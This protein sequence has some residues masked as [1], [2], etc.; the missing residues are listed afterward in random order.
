[1]YA[2]DGSML[3]YACKLMLSFAHTRELSTYMTVR[4][5]CMARSTWLQGTLPPQ[6]RSS[7]VADN[8]RYAWHCYQEH[9][10]LSVFS[11]P[12]NVFHLPGLQCACRADNV[13]IIYV[14]SHHW[15]WCNGVLL[16]PACHLVPP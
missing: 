1:M 3:V 9:Q 16:H 13:F 6:M 11:L 15:H 7:A 2:N 4:A 8:C 5:S 10:H 12:L 14:A